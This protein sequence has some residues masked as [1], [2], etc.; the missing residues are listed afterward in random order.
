MVGLSQD[1]L[2]Q[3]VRG[4]PPVGNVQGTL[5]GRSLSGNTE[6]LQ[7][8]SERLHVISMKSEERTL[9]IALF[10][11]QSMKTGSKSGQHLCLQNW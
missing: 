1:L 9:L 8:H 3:H 11:Y 6:R 7:K 2:V 10:I 4:L 5:L